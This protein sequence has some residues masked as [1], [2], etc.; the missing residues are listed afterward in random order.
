VFEQTGILERE[1]RLDKGRLEETG[2]RSPLGYGTLH[3]MDHHGQSLIS[4]LR[5][6][7]DAFEASR[8]ASRVAK[9]ATLDAV[10]SSALG[11]VG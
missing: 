11:R 3:P 1:R 7:K 4:H 8:T 6:A 9:I 10:C 2:L 5:A